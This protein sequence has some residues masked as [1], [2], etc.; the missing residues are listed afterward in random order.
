MQDFL[1]KY[2]TE[3]QQK[4]VDV[5]NLNQTWV[6]YLNTYVL[7]SDPKIAENALNVNWTEWIYGTGYI[8]KYANLDFSN[9]DTADTLSLVN[10]YVDLEGQKSPENFARYSKYYTGQKIVFLN[11][12]I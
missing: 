3:F 8:P 1:R 11:T 7:P 5:S 4:S 2:I 10:E 6:T 9:P 12:L